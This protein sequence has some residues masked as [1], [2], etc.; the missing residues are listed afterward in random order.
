MQGLPAHEPGLN[1]LQ[2]GAAPQKCRNVVLIVRGSRWLVLLWRSGVESSWA[3]LGRGGL[4]RLL[5]LGWNGGE[6]SG[7]A[8]LFPSLHEAGLLSY[9]CFCP[10]LR[11]LA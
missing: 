5:P 7:R 10:R 4:L 6:V 1:Q 8:G 9:V 3:G 11:T 2:S